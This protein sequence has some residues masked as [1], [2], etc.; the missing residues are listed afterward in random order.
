MILYST[1]YHYRER[2]REG[3]RPLCNSLQPWP[4]QTDAGKPPEPKEPE[5]DNQTKAQKLLET[6]WTL[7]SGRAL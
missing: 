5:M 7:L 4:C 3:E 6:Y 2:E 1:I